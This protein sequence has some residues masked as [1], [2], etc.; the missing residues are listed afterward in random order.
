M[1][2][3]GGRGKKR[4]R[5][6]S[7]LRLAYR[8]AERLGRHDVRRML[9]EMNALEWLEWKTYMHLEPSGIETQSIYMAHLMAAVW[10]VQIAKAQGAYDASKSKRGVRPEFRKPYELIVRMGDMPDYAPPKKPAG[11]GIFD[12]I[13]DHFQS[14]GFKPVKR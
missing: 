4:L 6:G 14:L 11:R 9:G 7:E 12:A 2:D 3:A 1:G 13:D 5:R 8:L 10:N